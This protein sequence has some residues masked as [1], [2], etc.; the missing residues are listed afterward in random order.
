V[1]VAAD[2]DDDRKP[3]AYGPPAELIPGGVELNVII[4]SSEHGQV[5]LGG[6]LAYP[7]GVQLTVSYSVA[8]SSGVD[9]VETYGFPNVAIEY[10]SGDRFST[11]GL[12]AEAIIDNET[13][14]AL[15][16]GASSSQNHGDWEYWLSPLPGPGALSVSCTWTRC[17]IKPTD[18]EIDT[19]AIRDAASRARP[20]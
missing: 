8:G 6:L 17:G 14:V 15:D 13:F 9:L 2:E 10:P 1:R 20:R 18:T 5:L 16:L 11:D 12:L 3:N 19:A 7:T 4:G